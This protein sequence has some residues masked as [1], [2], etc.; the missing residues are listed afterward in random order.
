MSPGR[1]LALVGLAVAMVV[2]VTAGTGAFSAT[3]TDRGIEVAV[4]DDDE[5]YLGIETEP[6]SVP[7]NATTTVALATFTNRFPSAVDVSVTVTE[8]TDS[9][10]TVG[11]LA[12]PGTLESGERGTLSADLT[13]DDSAAEARVDL[14]VRATGPETSVELTRTVAVA[15]EQRPECT[16]T[17]K[18]DSDEETDVASTELGTDN[19]AETN[20]G[21]D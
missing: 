4:V 16:E 6:V 7:G 1:R 5:A 10:P 12:G 21:D 15:C 11:A 2:A 18:G 9:V 13:C 8:G 3:A 20:A 17:D 19:A 14:E